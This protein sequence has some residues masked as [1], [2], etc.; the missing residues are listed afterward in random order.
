MAPTLSRLPLFVQQPRAKRAS[1]RSSER[2]HSLLS[3]PTSIET[4]KS[5]K[6]KGEDGDDK[7]WNDAFDNDTDE[8]TYPQSDTSLLNPK[9]AGAPVEIATSKDQ[10][11]SELARTKIADG[12]RAYLKLPVEVK[13]VAVSC[14]T[15]RLESVTN[16][17]DRP[18]L[19]VALVVYGDDHDAV[20]CTVDESCLSD[21]SAKMILVRM[22]NQVPLLDGAE[23]LACGLVQGI[24]S[25]QSLWN[26]FGLEV[27][28]MSRDSSRKSA[29]STE[30]A[31]EQFL[32]PA[33]FFVPTFRVRDSEQVAPFFQQGTHHLFE[34]EHENVSS[35]D[36]DNGD[37]E[38]SVLS[39]G[40]RK[41]TRTRP[42]LLPAQVRLGNILIMVNIHAKPTALPLP[43]LSKVTFAVELENS[44]NVSP[45]ACF[46]AVGTIAVE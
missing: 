10:A 8:K 15:I 1:P 17:E 32:D 39:R 13:N 40:K 6:E 25:K 24:A 31:D 36:D 26:S 42:L 37:I 14:Q 43:T 29:A 2:Q 46:H 5:Q 33:N 19:E 30:N 28:N 35:D 22:V 7:P 44:M 23:A 16:A 41:K 3:L 38:Q 45:H 34:E 18:T 20:E 4:T 12:V 21:R 9:K 11:T 27:T